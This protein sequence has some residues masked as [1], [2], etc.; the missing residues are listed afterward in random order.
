MEQG[1][2]TNPSSG[3]LPKHNERSN[4]VLNVDGVREDSIGTNSDS[5]K[6]R[7]YSNLEECLMMPAPASFDIQFKILHT[8]PNRI[9]VSAEDLRALCFKSKD[10]SLSFRFAFHVKDSSAE[11]DVLCFGAIARK[12]LRISEE[13]V[14]TSS[15]KC[16]EALTALKSI[17]TSESSVKGTIRSTLG[18][19]NKIYFI[20]RSLDD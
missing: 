18:K 19:D 17:I 2:P 10:G 4:Q 7:Q 6:K 5:S 14:A 15:R 20:L 12:I 11:I 16:E 8:I 3:I 13:D 1:V 9:F